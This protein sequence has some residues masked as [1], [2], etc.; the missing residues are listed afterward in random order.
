MAMVSYTGE[1]MSS[2]PL[3]EKLQKFRDTNILGAQENKVLNDIRILSLS[4][5]L[6]FGHSLKDVPRLC[7]YV[8]TAPIF[9]VWRIFLA[10][11]TSKRS[12]WLLSP[13]NKYTCPLKV[14]FFVCEVKK[15]G[16]SGNKHESDFA[17]VHR[18]I[19]CQVSVGISDPKSFSLL[20]E[21]FDCYLY[22]MSL[23]N[24]GQY[25]SRLLTQF[26]T[27]RDANDLMLLVPMINTL[28]FLNLYSYSRDA[29]LIF[30]CEAFTQINFISRHL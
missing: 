2:S 3:T 23:K 11:E 10:S 12:P 25:F 1:E 8:R 14:D 16:C 4:F 28:S 27:I 19:D 7:E 21:G 15:P 22:Q 13:L 24:S 30:V 17:K 5:I 29:D 6:V 26:R 20:V 9:V 18:E